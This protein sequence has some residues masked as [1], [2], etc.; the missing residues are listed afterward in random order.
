MCLSS[1]RLTATTL[2]Q[3][4]RP[5][6]SIQA[7][8]AM[9][10]RWSSAATNVQ[11]TWKNKKN[12]LSYWHSANVVSYFYFIRSDTFSNV[13]IKR[14]AQRKKTLHAVTLLWMAEPLHSRITWAQM[15]A[16]KRFLWMEVRSDFGMLWQNKKRSLHHRSSIHA[17]ITHASTTVFSVCSAHLHV[18]I[19][20]CVRARV[21]VCVHL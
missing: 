5:S 9:K 11:A 13:K 1:L 3:S 16:M 18:L 7:N 20:V 2:L 17:L 12:I 19:H 8:A 14:E 6:T 4:S 10:K 15:R 21:C